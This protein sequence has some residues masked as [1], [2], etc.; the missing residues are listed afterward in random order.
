M[1]NTKLNFVIENLNHQLN[2]R[3][4][5]LWRIFSWT[6]GIMISIIGG[7][8]LLP[9]IQ[10]VVLNTN[11]KII[12][13]LVIIIFTIY[14]YLMIK[15]GLTNERKIRDQLDKIFSEELNYPVYKELR[16]DRAKFGYNIVVLLMGVVALAA[17]WLTSLG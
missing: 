7:V 12:I 10:K 11:E 16:P 2:Q 15:E 1:D 17:T 5:K 9:R 6:S 13:S 4:E 14:S 8:F 3:L